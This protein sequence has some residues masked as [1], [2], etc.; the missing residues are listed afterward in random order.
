MQHE[1]DHLDGILSLDRITDLKTMAVREE[2]ESRYRD[3]SPYAR[4][5]D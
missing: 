1:I 2:F 4:G 3:A 5:N